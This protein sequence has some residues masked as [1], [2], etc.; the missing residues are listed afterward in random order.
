M[1]KTSA[2][3]GVFIDRNDVWKLKAQSQWMREWF[4]PWEIC[5]D[6]V[7]GKLRQARTFDKHEKLHKWTPMEHPR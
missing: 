5:H 4:M 6:Y 1:F 2:G 3:E 7:E